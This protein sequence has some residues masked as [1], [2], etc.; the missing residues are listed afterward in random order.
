MDEDEK[1]RSI[2]ESARDMADPNFTYPDASNIADFFGI[3]VPDLYGGSVSEERRQ[4]AYARFRSL[5]PAV[6]AATII[7]LF[8]AQY[9]NGGVDQ[10]VWNYREIAFDTAD[11]FEAVGAD[12]TAKL[13]RSLGVEL[14]G[15]LGEENE[16]LGAVSAFLQYRQELGGPAH[17]SWLGFD[18][19]EE[20]REAILEWAQRHP[21]AFVY[22]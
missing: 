22:R 8:V 10:F 1:L 21:E 3:D 20:V 6:R 4:S 7:D 14:A 12:N 5:P 2:R 17:G 18:P 16:A 19:V 9:R 11:A 13:I 15:S